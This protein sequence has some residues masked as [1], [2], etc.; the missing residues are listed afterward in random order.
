MTISVAIT[1]ITTNW[2]NAGVHLI[3]TDRAATHGLWQRLRARLPRSTVSTAPNTLSACPSW[4][5]QLSQSFLGAQQVHWLELPAP[6]APKAKKEVFSFLSMY[7]GPHAIWLVLDEQSARE[8][9]GQSVGRYV[10]PSALKVAQLTVLAPIIGGS[11]GTQVL[12]RSGVT[13]LLG[14]ISIDAACSVVEHAEFVPMRTPETTRQYLMRLMP[15]EGSLLTL[16]ELFFGRHW[17]RFLTVWEQTQGQYSDMFWVA[18]WTDQCWRAYWTCYYLSKGQHT[19]ARSI[20]YRLPAAFSRT[21]WQQQSKKTLL[22]L[23]SQLSFF[24]TRVKKGSLFAL[25]ELLTAAI[26]AI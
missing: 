14:S 4:I 24:D 13:R 8:V 22:N 10:V 26:N 2:Q 15:Y 16:S 12:Q 23:F 25:N 11:R 18:F 19:R 9:R 20:S 1:A 5:G 21:I 7:Q 3:V 6:W 17:Q